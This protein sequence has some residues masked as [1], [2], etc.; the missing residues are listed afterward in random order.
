MQRINH[1]GLPEGHATSATAAV[2]GYHNA[3]LSETHTFNSH[4]VNNLIVSYQHEN[5]SRGP[6]AGGIS[7]A[8]LSVNIWQP[9]FKQINQIQVGS[10][11]TVGDNPQGQFLRNGYTLRDDLHDLIRSHSLSFG[12]TAEIAKMDINNL[13]QQPGVFGFNSN[14]TGD[15][16]ASFLFG[17]LNTFGQASGQFTNTRGKF[18]GFYVEDSW[19][20]SKNFNLNYGL[21]YEPLY[22]WHDIQHRMEGFSLANY[23]AGIHS[24]VYPNAPI[25]MQFAGD[26]GFLSNGV[27]NEYTHFMPAL[28]L[29]GTSLETASSVFEVAV[30]RFMILV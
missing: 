11:F 26:P 17:Y 1:A 23:I 6:L 18:F 4:I 14:N 15:V 12:L 25:G 30:E 16:M 22:P 3:L 24:T 2:L 9:A 8:D 20:L 5:S 21:R 29:R 27:P 10:D 28:D 19:K 13:Y 7:V